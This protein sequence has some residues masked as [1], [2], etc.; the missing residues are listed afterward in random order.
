M[1]RCIAEASDNRL[2]LALFDA[3]NAVRRAVVWGLLR[4]NTERP[5]D[6]HHSF[7]EHELILEA[8]EKRDLEGASR[9][10][11]RHLR[12]VERNLIEPDIAAG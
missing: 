1:H 4:S 9:A 12:A 11:Y 3:L 5:P 10:M 2:L 6:D 8:I 7:A